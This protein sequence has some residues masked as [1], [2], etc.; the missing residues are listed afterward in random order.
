VP[1]VRYHSA[2]VRLDPGDIIV[3]FTDGIA[4]ARSAGREEFGERR[5]A[6]LVAGLWG[7]QADE[8]ADRIA[9]GVAEWSGRGPADDQTFVVVRVLSG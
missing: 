6:A 8:I 2:E 3:L 4:E 5:L 7:A 1:D 9:A